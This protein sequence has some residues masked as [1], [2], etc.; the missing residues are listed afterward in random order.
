MSAEQFWQQDPWLAVAYRRADEIK[1]QNRSYDLWLAGA[2]TFNA[3]STA[4]YNALKKKGARPQKY[5]EE[6]F[7][8]IP[9]SE[10]EKEQIA[11]RERQ[12]TIDYFNR[13]TEK[14]NKKH[15]AECQVPSA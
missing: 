15:S 12:K 9:Y 2:Y 3:A 11:A 8:V 10:E 7:R 14:W 5:L 6:P 4:V 13:L 1:R